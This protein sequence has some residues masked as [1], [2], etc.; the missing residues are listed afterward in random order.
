MVNSS[1]TVRTLQELVALAKSKPGALSYA[2]PGNGGASHLLGELLLQETGTKMVHVPYRGSALAATDTISGQVQ[3]TFVEL[4]VVAPHVRSGALR[5]L[6]ITSKTRSLATPD[7]PSR[8]RPANTV[9]TL[10][11]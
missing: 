3:V 11:S 9:L 7:V 4:A 8:K 5:E 6:G 10:R 2:S 1:L